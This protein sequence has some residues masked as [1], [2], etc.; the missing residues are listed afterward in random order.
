MDWDAVRNVNNGL[1]QTAKMTLLEYLPIPMCTTYKDMFAG[2]G[3]Y[4]FGT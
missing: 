1:V 2:K 4:K 3:H